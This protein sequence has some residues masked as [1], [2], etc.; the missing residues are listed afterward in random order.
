MPPPAHRADRSGRIA[1]KTGTSA[2]VWPFDGAS[3][4]QRELVR[5]SVPARLLRRGLDMLTGI[6]SGS[7]LQAGLLSSDSSRCFQQG[8][9]A[10][11]AL[12]R[13][14]ATMSLSDFRPEPVPRLWIPAGRWGRAPLCRISQVPR[15]IYPCALSPT[16]PEG[17]AGA[18]ARCFPADVR[19]HPLWRTGHLH[20][21]HEAESGSITTARRFALPVSTGQIAP[22][23]S[24]SATCTNELFTLVSTFQLTRSAR[25][26]LVYQRRKEER[27]TRT[28]ADV[29]LAKAQRR[30]GGREP[31]GCVSRKGR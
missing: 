16:T 29:C 25:L 20:S 15:L 6:R 4:Q 31:H 1:H 12:P 27:R 28:R 19:L 13:F 9:F 23:R 26:S 3:S 2:P 7:F 10:P 30:T 22:S 8:P 17:P 24:G 18:F 14:L 5:E 11:R 21:R